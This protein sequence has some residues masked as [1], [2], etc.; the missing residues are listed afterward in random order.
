[1]VAKKLPFILI[2]LFSLPLILPFFNDGFF[3]MH[4]DTQPARVYEMA[5][6]LRDGQ[7]PVRWVADLGYGFGYPLFNFYAPLPYYFGAIW[8]LIGFD[9]LIATKIMFGFPIILSVAAMYLLI[10]KFASSSYSLFVGVLYG[11]APYHA[12]EIYVRGAVG[13]YWAYAILPLV[14]LGILETKK[15]LKG[16]IIGSVSFAA[17]FLSHTISALLL[18]YVLGL[19]LLVELLSSLIKHKVTVTAKNIFVVALLG[20]G[21]SA[22]FWLPALSESSFTKVDVLRQGTNDFRNHFVY[23]DQLWDSPWG[24]AGSAPGRNDG[25]SFKIGKVHLI[26]LFLCGLFLLHQLVLNKKKVGVQV[27]LIFAGLLLSLVLLFPISKPAWEVLPFFAFIQYP[28]RLLLFV[29]FFIAFFIGVSGGKLFDFKS[30]F[31]K[32]AVVVVTILVIGVNTKYFKPNYTIPAH[33]TDYT[34]AEALRYKIS[35]ISDEY[36]PKYFPI[37]S[38]IEKSA[39]VPIA[40][41]DDIII[42]RVESKTHWLKAE[43]VVQE[44]AD[45][46]FSYAYFPGWKVVVDN[47]YE[48]PI[49]TNGLPVIT[50][51]PG[52]HTITAYFGST[53]P[54]LIG[55][56]LSFVS[57]FVFL[58]LITKFY[59]KKK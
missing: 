9:V 31:V 36:T 55:N 24:F 32:T 50:L 59:A 17:L 34:S 14:F 28:W 48:K 44:E 40:N 11:Y 56:F 49:I 15:S 27:L 53:L 18:I 30:K 26:S 45:L 54:R 37:P 16:I 46:V 1:M 19:W 21:L 5:K 51:T 33:L 58:G 4:D 57:L 47:R 23:I 52:K 8:L 42:E 29:S 22:F 13:E 7:F 25:M 38:T 6:S 20:F 10:R 2:L 41:Q 39:Q 43:V 35:K 12:V 3:P